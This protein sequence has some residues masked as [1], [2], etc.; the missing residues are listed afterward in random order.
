MR[1]GEGHDAAG[2]SSSGPKPAGPAS[3]RGDRRAG[4][5]WAHFHTFRHTCATTLFGGGRTQHGFRSGWAPFTPPSR[6]NVRPP[7]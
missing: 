6:R 5:P 2:R 3:A 4:V 7:A 1:L